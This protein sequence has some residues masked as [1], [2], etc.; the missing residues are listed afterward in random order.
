[1]G[2]TLRPNLSKQLHRQEM[3]LLTELEEDLVGLRGYRHV[4]PNGAVPF[5]EAGEAY[6]LEPGVGPIIEEYV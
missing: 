4:A 1:M 2:R 6:K 3:P 5:A